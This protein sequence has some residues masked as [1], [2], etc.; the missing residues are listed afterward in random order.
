M[1]ADFE[2]DRRTVWLAEGLLPYLSNAAAAG[3]LTV[4]GDLSPSGSQL[5]FEYDEFADDATLT[6]ARG[7]ARHAVGHLA[8]GGRAR[9]ERRR[10]AGCAS[11]DVS[12]HNRSNLAAEY[13]RPTQDRSRAGLL[14]ATRVGP[15]DVVPVAPREGE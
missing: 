5:S 2:S 4:I 9:R 13:G 6:Q 8:V 3:L 12:T 7:S 11:V 15:H 1:G 10:L 14:T